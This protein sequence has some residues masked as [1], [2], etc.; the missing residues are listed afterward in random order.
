M[1][2]HAATRE[3]KRQRATGVG[4]VY[5]GAAQPDADKGI[6]AYVNAPRGEARLELMQYRGLVKQKQICQILARLLLHAAH[7]QVVVANG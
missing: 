7:G 3:I 4:N 6:R 2:A 1:S 5:K